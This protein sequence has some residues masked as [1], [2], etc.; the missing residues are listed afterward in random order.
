MVELLNTFPA[1]GATPGVDFTADAMNFTFVP[2]D[3][4]SADFKLGQDH[5]DDPFMFVHFEAGQTEAQLVL[6]IVNDGLAEPM[7]EAFALHFDFASNGSSVMFD[8]AL[9]QQLYLAAY[10]GANATQV[11]IGHIAGKFI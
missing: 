6:H 1:G 11:N 4:G 2:A 5:W 9:S 3:A 8:G 10:P 7:G